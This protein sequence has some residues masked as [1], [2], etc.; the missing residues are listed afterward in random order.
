[1]QINDHVLEKLFQKLDKL[2]TEVYYLNKFKKEQE[3]KQRQEYYK[4][5]LEK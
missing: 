4:Q 2:E 3:E 5:K 1:M